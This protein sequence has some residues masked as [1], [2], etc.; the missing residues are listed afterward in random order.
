MFIFQSDRYCSKEFLKRF[1]SDLCLPALPWNCVCP[2]PDIPL[3]LTLNLLWQQDIY[4]HTR[5]SHQTRWFE[6]FENFWSFTEPLTVGIFSS[7]TRHQGTPNSKVIILLS[8]QQNLWIMS[9]LFLYRFFTPFPYFLTLFF[10]KESSKVYCTRS[11][12]VIIPRRQAETCHTTSGCTLTMAVPAQ[13]CLKS[14]SCVCLLELIF[15]FLL[16]FCPYFLPFLPLF[17]SL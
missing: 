2:H 16:F 12:L 15:Y 4:I 5:W 11:N 7:L 9:S 17:L 14:M 6:Y 3:H 13:Y 10:L 8:L 1:S